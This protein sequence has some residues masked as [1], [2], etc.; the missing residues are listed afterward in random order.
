MEDFPFKLG[1][2]TTLNVAGNHLRDVKGT[3]D[4][5]CFYIQRCTLL[6]QAGFCLCSC[7][8][9]VGSAV[10]KGCPSGGGG[11]PTFF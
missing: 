6:D 1:A 10:A 5:K 8:V 7:K 11:E 4:G 2:I 9:Y 3:L